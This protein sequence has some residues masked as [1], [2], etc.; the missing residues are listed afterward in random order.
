MKENKMF[1]AMVEEL[2][3]MNVEFSIIDDTILC[4]IN[5]KEVTIYGCDKL[6][7]CFSFYNAKKNEL[8]KREERRRRKQYKTV[9]WDA[10]SNMYRTTNFCRG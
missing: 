5:E 7:V 8:V 4:K 10:F 1:N 3:K 9:A 6:G 2:K